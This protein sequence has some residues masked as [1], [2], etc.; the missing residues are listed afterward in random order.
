MVLQAEAITSDLEAEAEPRQFSELLRALGNLVHR[1]MA[2]FGF[3]II[4]LAITMAIF[5]GYIAPYD[6]FFQ[7]PEKLLKPPLWSLPGDGPMHILGTDYLGRDVLSR[8]IYGS[9]VSLLV[10]FA[11]VFIS[12]SIGLTLGIVSGYFGGYVDTI[13][14]RIVDV[15]LAFPFILLALTLIAIFKPSLAVIILVISLR[16]WIIY[17]RVI[18]G[19]VLSV[20]EQDFVQAALANGSSTWRIM[21]RHILPNVFAP[22][23]VIATLY[24]GRMIIIESSLSYLGLGV[25]PTDPRWGVTWGNMLADGKLYL[26]TAWWIAAFPGLAIMILVMGFNLFGDWLRDILD[27][28]LKTSE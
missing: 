6:P 1:K 2:L 15:A 23:L 28:K 18:R 7:N 12:G 4:V 9:R 27:P 22:A 5:A 24:L 13:L 19:S 25:P 11:A 8:V 10:G 20:R 3:L 26:D 17:A 21:F 14:M 16:T